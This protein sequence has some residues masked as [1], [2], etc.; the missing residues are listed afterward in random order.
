MATIR[1]SKSH[2]LDRESV[3]L[4]VQKLA[5][6]LGRELAA[7]HRWHGDRLVFTRSG[8]EGYVEI[9][10]GDLKIEIRLGMLLTPLKGSI[11]ASIR[12]YLDRHLISPSS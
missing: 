11:E 1:F 5:D 8:A 6:K 2:L 7:E 4:E 9:G 3:R 10:D 12:E